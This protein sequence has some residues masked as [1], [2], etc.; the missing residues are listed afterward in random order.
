MPYL[1]GLLALAALP[2]WPQTNPT[3]T[4]S[5]KVVDQQGL[6]IPG[7]LVSAQSPALQGNRTATSSTNGDFILPFLPPGDYTL[8]F[9]L[10]GFTTVKRNERVT[11]GGTVQVTA[12]LSVST[13]TETV[14]VMGEAG[15]DFGK[16]SQV[17]TSFKKELVDNLPLGRTLQAATLLAP[18]VQNT[19]PNGNITVSG[20]MSYESLYLVN[21]VVVNENIRGQAFN[22]FI[23][24]A[25]QETTISTAG[26]SA[27]YGRFGGGV[28]NAITKSGGNAF[29]GSARVTLDNDKWIALTPFRNDKR[30]DDVIPTYEFT[31]GGP[32]VKDRLWFFGAAR[33][34]DFKESLTT[35]FTNFNYPHELNEKRYEGKLTWSVSPKHTFKGA[36]SR[37][38][39]DE[40][41]NSF[42]TILD[43]ASLVNRSL[44]QQLISAN[45]TGIVRSNFFVE[46][47]YS[48]RR[49]SFL[50][51]GAQF[52][53][54][55]KGTM[56]LDRSRNSARYWSP[57]FC[58]VCDP[59]K[60]DNQNVIAKAS[61]F[62]STASAG[63]H[64]IV[65]GFD[66][67]DDKRFAN[68]HQSGSDYRILG[69]S[70]IIQGATIYPVFN[71]DRT[72]IIQWNPILVSSKGNRFR[73]YSGFLNDTWTLKRW[74]FNAGVR[75]DKNSG[76]DAAG[77]QVVKDSSFSPRLSASWDV[78]GDGKWTLNA[79]Y[80]QYVAA[81]ANSQGDAG[82]AGGQPAT[83]QFD[84]L[85]PAVNVGNPASPVTADQALKTLFDWFQANG[86]TDRATRGA[87]S[88]PGV[89]RKVGG[90]LNSPHN[91]E[92]S[93]GLAGRLGSRG[94]YRVDGVYRRFRDFY[95][96]RVDLSTGSVAD[97]FGRRFDLRIVENTD[98]VERNYKGINFQLSYRP[99]TRL[100]L[101]GNY[102]LSRT[103][104]SFDGETGGSGPVRS[105][106]QFY[107]Q[108]F[109]SSW[110][111]PVGDLLTDSRHKLRLWATYE[112]PLPKLLGKLTL[113][114][115]QFFNSGT[116]YG[117]VGGVDTRPFVTNPGYLTPPSAVDY[118]FEPRDTYRM[119]NLVRTD[120]SVNWSR[121]VGV[122]NTELFFRGTVLNA[123][124]RNKLTNFFDGGCGTG[125]CIDTTIQTNS[126]LSSLAAFNPFTQ[127][128]VE[129]VNWKK[130][131]SFGQATSR[132]GYQTPRTY[133]FS[134][135][136][137]F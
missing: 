35:G 59:E 46:G 48:R 26:I 77:S 126:S 66:M 98:E 88:I 103:R 54:L 78:K 99:Q 75:F 136:L 42:G 8:S 80:A 51:S 121:K 9:E 31:L 118:F 5:G 132:F 73:T 1:F 19:G 104:G 110:N 81:I 32:F 24:D 33:L 29:S 27:E 44:P 105:S 124:N 119:A 109:A 90:N 108:Y 16:G 133:G 52:T 43:Q 38:T 102:T 100:N 61:Y 12:T 72:T 101:G 134:V 63:S 129:G 76:T 120:F 23:E 74:R 60:R 57:T 86:G 87:P 113:G 47:Q 17:A 45:Y 40:I 55:I 68:N 39:N 62:L 122:R 131:D 36:Y 91:E 14:T 64:N 2:A 79:N 34:R 22:L 96:E 18:G 123:F 85:G 13:V 116:P 21:G 3:G 30:S 137:R 28:I 114:A 49:F 117:S 112:A 6:A 56:L 67:F 4:I 20:A 82:S 25:L 69:T 135:G 37:I 115:L 127:T 7:A 93:L 65:A 92:F 97:P 128:P 111:F 107:P 53:D 125:G 94:T 70:A 106:P 83:F 130:G 15:G 95:A 11:P 71:N 41:G 50:N 89:N 10:S 58:G 84:Y